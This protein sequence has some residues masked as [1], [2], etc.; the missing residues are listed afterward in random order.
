MADKHT[1]STSPTGMPYPPICDYGFI[2][3]CHATALVSKDGS[4]DWCCMPRIDSASLFGRIL[5]WNTGGYCRI[6][7]TAAFRSSRSY[8]DGT[9]ILETIFTTDSGKLRM[10]D[11][12]P[13]RRGG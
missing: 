1:T 10:L 11:F 7:P 3:D 8:L 6:C 12:F 4:I 9:L 2:S 13:M 5:G